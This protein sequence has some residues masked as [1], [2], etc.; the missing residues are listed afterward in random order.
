MR[1]KILIGISRGMMYL[2]KHHIMH[3]DLKHENIILDENFNPLITDFGLSKYSETGQSAN[4]TQYIGTSAYIA[5]EIING[6][7]YNS[8]ADV[9]SF[10]II[11]YEIITDSIP[12]PLF[13]SG[14]M[15]LFQF[16]NKVVNEG[17]RPEFTVPV[18]ESLKKLIE[19][20][21]SKD[22][23]QRPTFE[24]LFNKLAFNIEESIYDALDQNDSNYYL[25]NVEVDELFDYSTFKDVKFIIF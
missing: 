19:K 13:Q 3:R 7:R 16:N 6:N 12:Y 24:Q 22:L 25:N 8:K 15:P 14:K 17:Y 23:N 20:C 4:Q 21:W 10:G 18:Q 9:Y 1:Q 5:P 2:H 11:M